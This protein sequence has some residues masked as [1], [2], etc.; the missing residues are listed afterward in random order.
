MGK[1]GKERK[2][3]RLL[4]TTNELATSASYPAAS[5]KKV[6]AAEHTQAENG[7]KRQRRDDEDDDWDE[8]QEHEMDLNL[9]DE[10]TGITT[11]QLATSMGVLMKL[12][13]NPETLRLPVFKPLR[14]MLHKLVKAASDSGIN[15]GSTLS[16]RISEAISDKRWKES[17]QGLLEMREKGMKPKLGALQ[18]WVRDCDAANSFKKNGRDQ[19]V[20]EVLDSILRTADPSLVG[21]A[22][23]RANEKVPVISDCSYRHEPWSPDDDGLVRE[24]ADGA[25]R[26]GMLIQPSDED[27]SH[28]K[29]LFKILAEEP[30]H[31][32][33][34]PNKHPM[35]LYTT[36]PNTISLSP[37]PPTKKIP[38]PMIP[39]S[40]MIRDLFTASECSQILRAM[41]SIGFTADEPLEQGA[42][43]GAS[44]LAHNVFWMA[45]E[46]LLRTIEKRIEGMFPETL[47]CE[48]DGGEGGGGTVKRKYAG[49]NARWRVY[50]YVPGHVYRPHID[51]AWPKSGVDPLSGEYVYD[52]SGGKA[53]SRMTF[54]IYL[55]QNFKGGETT[56]FLPSVKSGVMDARAV[57]P[58]AGSVAVFPHGCVKNVLLHEGSGVI[59]GA[60]YIIRTDVLYAKE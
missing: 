22:K 7:F 14:A 58:Q 40:F 44:V 31:T 12:E 41:E 38:I 56:F 35:I 33:R 32:R 6:V 43:G 13:R 48:E 39:S 47:I 2:K 54:L 3:R 21:F 11:H 5:T 27:R 45:D 60:K 53:W 55:N 52:A 4:Q 34:P 28:F 36:L 23:S 8:G 18:R 15:A 24:S 59:E 20:L 37:P 17:L 30:G 51:G 42:S 29:P 50:R 46:G 26:L 16:G 9:A 19:E 10:T 1:T 49:I 57:T 25:E